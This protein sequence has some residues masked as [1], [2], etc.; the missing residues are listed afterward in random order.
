MKMVASA[1]LHKA[2]GRIGNMLP[3]QRKLNEI[4]TNFLRTDASFESP[5]TEKRPVTRVA[6]VAFS[7]N[8]SLCGA[9]NS[10]VA[11][12]LE[13][14][15]EDYQSLGKENILIYPVGRKVEEA[16]KKMGYVPQGSYQVMA[17]KPSYVEAYELAEKLMHEFVEKQIDHVELIYHHFKS[18]GS[19]VLLRENY[20]PI[21]LT[22]VAQEAAEDVPEDARSFNNDYIVEPS[23]GELIAELL[24]KV[25]SQKIFTVLLDSNTSEHAA[26]MLAMQ[27]A[28][29]NANELIQDLTKQYNKSRQQA[30]TNELLDIIGGSLK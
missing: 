8:S 30:I 29:D 11:K 14:T 28:T 26:R 22:Q 17:D 23:V 9:F 25:L 2:Q 18:M 21:D 16:V 7:S 6:V 15:L 4:L 13:R 19:Q 12:M 27:T 24:P 3:Y 10:N 20:L 1:K 5:Y